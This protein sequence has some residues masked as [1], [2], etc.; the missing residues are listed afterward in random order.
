MVAIVLKNIG[1]RPAPGGQWPG[2]VQVTLSWTAG[3]KNVSAN[4][5]RRWLPD[6]GL[7]P[8]EEIVLVC[9]SQVPAE[10]IAYEL[11]AKVRRTHGGVLV[12]GLDRRASVITG[13]FGGHEIDPT[14]VTFRG[15]SL[16]RQWIPHPFF[17][18][19]VVEKD[20]SVSFVARGTD[21]NVLGPALRDLGRPL[22]VTL[23]YEAIVPPARKGVVLECYYVYEGGGR[24]DEPVA[25]RALVQTN[26][27]KTLKTVL[28]PHDGRGARRIRLDFGQRADYFRVLEVKIR[29][30]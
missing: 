11:A 17:A 2:G 7:K 16:L 6:S 12:S 14:D 21:T 28:E 30:L 9:Q 15:E 3:G 10:A 26:E 20:G 8:G 19:G 29:V 4:T 18:D 27:I 23:V 25:Q 5:Y 24:F 22:E 1:S 13:G